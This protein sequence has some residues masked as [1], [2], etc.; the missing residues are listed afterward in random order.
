MASSV[1]WGLD[2]GTTSLKAIKL[3]RAGDK[4]NVEAFDVIDH[5]HFLTEPDVNRD[6]VIRTSIMRFLE[7]NPI[8]RREPVFIGVPGST[9]F[10]RFVKLPPV[11]P[12]KIPEIV[13][14]EAIQQIPFP[15][16]QVN[17]DFKTFSNPDSPDVEVGIFAMKKDLVVQVL[18]N[19]VSN[20]VTVYGVQMN[21]L[22]VYNAV[23]YDGSDG[24]KGTVVLDIG[25]EHTDLVVVDRGRLWLRT[26]NIGGNNFTDALA[27]SF[28]L[29]FKKAE[30]L[31]KNAATSKYA[32]Q[33]Y[34]AMRPIFADL[35]TEVQRSIGYYTSAH[36]DSN[37][38]RM[39]GMGTPFKLPN[40]QKFLQQSLN[41]EVI[42]LENFQKANAEGKM[43]AGLAENILALPAAYGLALQGLGL[44]QIDTNLLPVEV[45]RQMLWK[46]KRPWFAAAAACV[47][48]GVVMQ[49]VRYSMDRSAFDAERNS[50]TAIQNTNTINKYDQLHT[51]YVQATDTYDTDLATIQSFT[52]LSQDRAFWPGIYRVLYDMLP[53]DHQP[54]IATESG[55][56]QQQNRIVVRF[57]TSDFKATLPPIDAPTGGAGGPGGFGGQPG[58]PPAVAGDRT[59]FSVVMAG[60][61]PH[62]DG[63]DVIRKYV[64]RLA[65]RVNSDDKL[66]Y[67]LEFGRTPFTGEVLTKGTPINFAGLNSSLVWGGS[68]SIGPFA[69]A[70]TPLLAALPP[71][72][73][74]A[75]PGG[76]PAPGTPYPFPGGAAGGGAPTATGLTDPIDPDTKQLQYGDFLF[77]LNFNILMKKR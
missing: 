9:T 2:V 6:E 38:E 20:N 23:S 74:A 47:V 31:K 44:G 27:K 54:D 59:G 43:G 12:K 63:V 60:Y 30:E 21:P 33:I 69:S 37:L 7:R 13:K 72:G 36:R 29:S 68:S 11:E 66:P 26:V 65:K 55:D 50:S 56:R 10:A 16:D 49:G 71:A 67:T 4:V 8:P 76:P 18:A 22:A 75:G 77:Q 25:A 35:A 45:A 42:R 64:D 46:A 53:Q 73:G 19:F 3:T 61:T 39:I 5:T 14:F 51:R 28:K 1:A 62:R 57:V 58:G 48:A 52:N 15:L 34:Q 41:M 70:Y 40:M 17:W 32:R 24:Q